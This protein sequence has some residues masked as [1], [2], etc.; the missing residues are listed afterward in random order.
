[1]AASIKLT[2]RLNI[3]GHW[4]RQIINSSSF[5]FQ[6]RIRSGRPAF[7]ASLMQ[8]NL[9]SY[10]LYHPHPTSSKLASPT[11]SRSAVDRSARQSSNEDDDRDDEGYDDDDWR[12]VEDPGERRKIQNRLAQRKFRK[13]YPMVPIFL[14]VAHQWQM[15]HLFNTP[16]PRPKKGFGRPGK[17]AYLRGCLHPEVGGRATSLCPVSFC[18]ISHRGLQISALY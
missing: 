8:R 16:S 11:M 9:A 17:G 15:Q 12:R 4:Q 6:L 2:F 14:P 7:K 3:K 5:A 10:K 18:H 13:S 1:M